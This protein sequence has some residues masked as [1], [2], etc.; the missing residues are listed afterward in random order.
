MTETGIGVPRVSVRHRETGLVRR[1]LSPLETFA[2]SL[3]ATGPSIAV[4]GT[5]PLA[6]LIAGNGAAFAFVIATVLLLLVGYSVA[7]FAARTSSTG[8]LYSY[9]ALGL[10]RLWG[11]VA[12]WALVIGYTGIAAATITGSALYGGAFFDA[13]GLSF[14][15]TSAGQVVLL[16]VFA[17]LAVYVPVRGVRLSTRVAVAL[18]AIS[19]TA[20]V[21]VLIATLVHN[22]F[23]LD[24]DQLR[25]SDT[26]VSSIG[27]AAVLAAAAFVGFES[28]ASLGVEARSP[29]RAVPR[30]VLGTVLGAGL[31]YIV[32]AYIQVVGFKASG[33]ALAQSSSPLGSLAADAGVGRLGPVV[34]LGIALSALACASASLNAASRI[35]FNLGREGVLPAAVGDA[36]RRFSTPHVAILVLGPIAYVVTVVLVLTGTDGLTIFGVTATVATFGYLLAYLLILIAA[37]RFL[38]ARGE[39]GTVAVVGGVLGVAGIGYVLVRNVYPVPDPPYDVLPYVF[40]GLLAIGVI[41]YVALARSAPGRADGLGALVEHADEQHTPATDEKASQ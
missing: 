31:L 41:G 34:D 28:S 7:Q 32:A 18:E 4:A 3:A 29:Y 1:Q 20:I 25:V 21:V 23:P 6:Y 2:Q 10:G 40:L 22:G 35:V 11:F 16:T 38:R 26:S 14:F 17:L 24:V 33:D 8:S 9:V 27:V 30:A 39:R 12:G 13:F 5:I 19:I 15:T 36:H 37:P